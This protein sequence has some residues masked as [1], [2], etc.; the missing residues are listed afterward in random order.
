MVDHVRLTIV[1][2]IATFTVVYC[3]F[4]AYFRLKFKFWSRQPVFHLHNIYYWIYY[5]FKES[6]IIT[7]K[8]PDDSRFFDEKIQVYNYLDFPTEKKEPLADFIRNNFLTKKRENFNPPDDYVLDTF[9]NHDNLVT[10]SI[11]EYNNKI[12][13]CMGMFPI[14]CKLN[15]TRIDV[16]YVDYLC[17]DKEHRK[18]NYAPNQIFTHLYHLQKMNNNFVCFF[19][20]ENKTNA[21]VPFTTYY[22]YMF[23]IE[24]WTFCYDFDQPNMSIVFID[25]KNLNKFHQIFQESINAFKYTFTPNLSHIFHLVEKQHIKIAALLINQE[26]F[27]YYIMRNAHTTYN[28][29][30]SLQVTTS[31]KNKNISDEVFTLG[32]L[33]SMSILSK[34][35]DTKVL[36]IE[37]ISNNNIILKL[38][39]EKYIYLAKIK[40]ALYFYNYVIHPK[41]S[42][43]TLCII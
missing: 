1:Y 27:G 29:D 37:N 30:K 18:K 23:K 14:K 22:N 39:L 19:K 5:Y 31:Y 24:N 25:K 38:L 42:E 33:I 43:D 10:V 4:I 2:T 15:E 40:N 6:G 13:A 11:K 17:V 26:F 20:R 35:W 41:K 34:D 32:F 7:D 21:L 16:N 9:N 12:L 36:F 3:L 28:G 8:L